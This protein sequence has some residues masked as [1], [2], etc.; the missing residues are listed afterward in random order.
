LRRWPSGS[1]R[2]PPPSSGIDVVSLSSFIRVDGTNDAQ[3]RPDA[4]QP[5]AARRSPVERQRHHPPAAA[6]DCRGP[7]IRSTCSRCRTDDRRTVSRGQY[8]FALQDANPDEFAVVSRLVERLQHSNIEDVATSHSETAFGVHPDRLATAGRFG[9][10]PATV[11]NAPMIVRAAH[12][13]DDLHPVEP[14][15][16]ILEADPAMQLS[17]FAHSIYL[18]S[19]TAAN[20]RA[21]V[22]APGHRA[23]R[24]WRSAISA[25]FSAMISASPGPRRRGGRCDPQ[26]RRRSASRPA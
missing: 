3:R 13:V 2:W 18:P 23:Q 15:S 25:S 19:S 9:I 12:R 11:D 14:V 5:E 16:V 1:R 22:V 4:D 21:A 24:R 20:G 6:R 8:Q 7:G 10:T 26:G 17:A